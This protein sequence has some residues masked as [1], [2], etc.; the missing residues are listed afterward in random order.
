MCTYVYVCIY[1]YT[2]IHTYMYVYT[3]IIIIT[4]IVTV[5]L[6]RAAE[7]L[8]AAQDLNTFCKTD[9]DEIN[10]RRRNSLYKTQ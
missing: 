6:R 8:A 10:R 3:A 2:Y 5:L 7:E 9:L 4:T 1:I